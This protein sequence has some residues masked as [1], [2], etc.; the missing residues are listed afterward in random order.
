VKNMKRNKLALLIL[1]AILPLLSLTGCN[2]D[3]RSVPPGYIGKMLTPT[4]WENQIHEAGQLDIGVQ[5]WDGR[6]NQ[7]VICEATSVTIKESFGKPTKEVS[8]DHRI[9]GKDK[10]PFSVDMYVQVMVPDEKKLRDSIFAQ[11]TPKPLQGGDG[12]VSRITLSDIY[13]RFAQMTIRGKAREIFTEYQGY[14]DVMGQYNLVSKRIA[15][16]IAETFEENKV[17]LK[18][19]AGQLSNVKADETVWAAE[20][21]KAA[22]TAQ[23]EVIDKIGVAMRNNP[24]YLE[25]YKWD[26]LKEIAGKQSLTIIVNSGGDGGRMSYTLPS[27]VPAERANK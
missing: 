3:I 9:I 4:G 17:P 15:G 23:V 14:Q 1:V 18:L 12:R 27:S 19:L 22:A 8:E 21:Q 24:A 10:V 20:N 7:L 6:S 26:V 13:I 5:G 2:N 25:K 16:M 11:V